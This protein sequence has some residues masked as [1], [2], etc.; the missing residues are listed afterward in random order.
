M[1]TW[2]S[3]FTTPGCRG[4]FADMRQCPDTFTPNNLIH[5]IW[6]EFGRRICRTWE[7]G[8]GSPSS[9]EPLGFCITFLQQA[10]YHVKRCAEPPCRTS[11]VPQKSGEPLGARTRLLRTGIFS[12]KAWLGSWHEIFMGSQTRTS[13]EKRSFASLT[14]KGL[15]LCGLMLD[16]KLIRPSLRGSLLKGVTTIACM[17]LWQFLLLPPTPPLSPFFP[18]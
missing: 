12:S 7:A 14:L 18:L 2:C 4:C 8:L 16:T 1:G 11:K 9:A 13:V 5:E 10:F 15:Q 17:Y 3:V 6:I